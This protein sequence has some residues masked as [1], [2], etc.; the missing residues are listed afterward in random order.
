M[1]IIDGFLC[2]RKDFQENVATAPG[3]VGKS[4]TYGLEMI[5]NP[6]WT[7]HVRARYLLGMQETF[8]PF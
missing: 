6:A 1:F 8:P 4:K 7:A 3:L 2:E 5:G